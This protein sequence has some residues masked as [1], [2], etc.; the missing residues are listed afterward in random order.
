MVVPATLLRCSRCG[1]VRLPASRI[2]MNVSQFHRNLSYIEWT[3]PKCRNGYREF[4]T[5]E[6]IQALAQV[7][8][9]LSKRVIPPPDEVNEPHPGPPLN[10][11][12]LI[13]FHLQLEE[14]R[15]LEDLNEALK[16]CS[17]STAPKKIPIRKP[18]DY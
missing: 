9:F 7:D 15:S 17:G 11:D 13:D 2:I 12:D 6:L 4:L 8:R 18:D 10:L 5:P 14:M 3:C 1:L 16:A